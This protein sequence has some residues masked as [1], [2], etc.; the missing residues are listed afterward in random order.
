MIVK[1]RKKYFLKFKKDITN[2]DNIKNELSELLKKSFKKLLNIN[3]Y[4]KENLYWSDQTYISGIFYPSQITYVSIAISNRLFNIPK[5][6]NQN[7]KSK[8]I[9][10][11]LAWFI[12][13]QIS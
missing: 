8:D 5:H 1:K 6:L 10:F 12:N 4:S 9:S 13:T 7:I 2:L 3:S 11:S